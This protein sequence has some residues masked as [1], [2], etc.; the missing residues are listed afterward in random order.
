MACNYFDPLLLIRSFKDASYSGGGNITAKGSLTDNSFFSAKLFHGRL[1]LD[2]KPMYISYSVSCIF[3]YSNC[4]PICLESPQ[5]RF[6]NFR[7]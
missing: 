7:C 3:F 4:F 1:L 5:Q 6:A 2:D